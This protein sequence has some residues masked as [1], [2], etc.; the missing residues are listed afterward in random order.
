MDTVIYTSEFCLGFDRREQYGAEFYD[1]DDVS[2]DN[3]NA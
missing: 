1:I 2:N 3:E